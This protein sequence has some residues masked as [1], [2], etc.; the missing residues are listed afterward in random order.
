MARHFL[1]RPEV[2]ALAVV[3]EDRGPLDRDQAEK[4]AHYLAQA[5]IRAFTVPAP[6]H[7]RGATWLLVRED[8]LQRA[9]ITLA[10]KWL[11]ERWLEP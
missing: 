4:L 1:T 6:E 2:T 8:D 10:C 3:R 11:S 7:L 9:E 5:M